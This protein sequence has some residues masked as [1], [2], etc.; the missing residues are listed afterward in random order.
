[1]FSIDLFQLEV[2][3][4]LSFSLVMVLHLQRKNIRK[5]LIVTK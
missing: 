2:F 5:L 4:R 1:M 3:S